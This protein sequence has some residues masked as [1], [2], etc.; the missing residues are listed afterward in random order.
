MPIFW[1]Y[2]D[3]ISSENLN[4]N[5]K[6]SSEYISPNCGFGW[7]TKVWLNWTK[8]G[9]RTG[10]NLVDFDRIFICFDYFLRE[11]TKISPYNIC[12]SIFQGIVDSLWK[13][14]RF[15]TQ[16]CLWYISLFLACRLMSA[17]LDLLSESLASSSSLFSQLMLKQHRD[18]KGMLLCPAGSM[19]WFYF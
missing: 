1:L 4:F 18:E 10:Q 2:F 17:P 5:W 9:S 3:S 12:T 15:M 7:L 8:F 14:L 16:V 11:L 13:V 19:L 6:Y